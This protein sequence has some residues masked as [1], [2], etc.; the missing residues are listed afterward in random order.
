MLF[1]NPVGSV[2]IESTVVVAAIL[3]LVGHLIGYNRNKPEL[4]FFPSPSTKAAFAITTVIFIIYLFAP[5]DVEPFIYF[6]F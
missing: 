1:L 6:Q 4:V 2:W 5:T 3:V